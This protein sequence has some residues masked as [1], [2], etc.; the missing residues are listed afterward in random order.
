MADDVP[1]VA[2]DARVRGS[3]RD[4]LLILLDRALLDAYRAAS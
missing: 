2:F 3:V 1:V 4:T